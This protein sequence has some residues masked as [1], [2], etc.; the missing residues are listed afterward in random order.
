[1]DWQLF[2]T[3][4][5]L[6]DR[7]FDSDRAELLAGLPGQGIAYVVDCG[8]EPSDWP[9]VA[10]NAGQPYIYV[11]YGI[12]PHSAGYT[13]SA[14][15]DVLAGY[16]QRDKCVA[17][18]EIGLDYHYDFSPRE[19]QKKWLQVQLELAASLNLPV[20][21]HDRE[22]HADMLAALKPFAGKLRGVLHCYSGS[23]EMVHDF[24][25][26]GLYL[27]FGGSSTFANAK[28]TRQ[29]AQAVPLDRMLLETDCPYLTPAPHRGKRN[30]PSYLRVICTTIADLRGMDALE[31]AR[32]TTRNACTLFGIQP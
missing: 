8:T 22:A 17:L 2:D 20:I 14:D 32:I 25:D 9:A 23:A 31:L 19:D 6:T 7:R 21:L 18:G 28:K 5:H 11:A 3:H 13:R 1:M 12:H 30:D 4:A 16:L 26:L 27:G 10:Q 15:I 24:L 29:A